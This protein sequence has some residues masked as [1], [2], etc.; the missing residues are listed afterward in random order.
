[1]KTVLLHF[2]IGLLAATGAI[3]QTAPV[4]TTNGK[5]YYILL[6]DG[7]HIHGRIIRRDSTMY[8]VRMRNGQ[9]T[10]VEKEQ[11]SRI[12]GSAP[13][14]ADSIAYFPQSNYSQPT[15]AQPNQSTVSPNQYEITLAD[16][17]KLNA[18][19][20]SQDSS[21]LVVKTGNLGTVYVP[22]NQV[23]R[24]ERSTVARSRQTGY[25]HPAEGYANL[26]PQY[27]NFTPTAFQAERGR[28]YYRNSF[29][30]VNQVDVGVTDNWSIGAGLVTPIA[31][32]WAGWL[33]TKV[34]VPI[35]PRA[36]VGIQAQYLLG[37]VMLFTNETFSASYV[38]G[39]VS[40]GSSQNNVTFGLGKSLDRNATGSLLTVGIVRRASPL[41]TFIS[42]NQ[43]SLT[44]GSR[45]SGKLGAGLRFD[46]QRHSFDVSANLA[47]GLYRGFSNQTIA[48]FLPW[49]SYQLRVGR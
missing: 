4:D 21:R 47:L 36:R 48:S 24:M 35:G 3:A 27:L 34:S 1:M 18:V 31:F 44:S 29:I 45:T 42:E 16:G 7:S 14:T 2:F 39:V 22:A 8:T 32:V 28:A 17:T 9:L 40:L 10:Y 41:L 26:F 37:S 23:I 13:V 11:F 12:S 43:L 5:P 20:I 19:V 38:Q 30:Y 33:A 49:A 6:K 15:V 46:R 25:A